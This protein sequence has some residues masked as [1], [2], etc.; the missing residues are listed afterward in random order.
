MLFRSHHSPFFPPPSAIVAR[1]YDLWF[2]GPAT[3]LLLTRGATS[4]ILPSLGRVCGGL[5]IA[6]AVG[7]PLGIA[8]GRS[9]A[10]SA[11]LE[12]LLHFGRSLPAVAFATVFTIAFSLGTQSEIAFI[13][14]GTTWPI[15]L[16]TIDGA[17][18]VDPLLGGV[19]AGSAAT[20]GLR[21]RRPDVTL[22]PGRW[23][24][25]APTH[26]PAT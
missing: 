4:N 13:A 26:A 7:V 15:L 12:P 9:A 17:R 19:Y 5:A 8:L 10:A 25:S 11:Y 1:M 23:K 16:N 20:I 21:G 3:H 14:F 2:S 6:I 18:S 22:D 24:T